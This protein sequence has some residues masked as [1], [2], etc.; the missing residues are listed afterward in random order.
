MTNILISGGAGYIGSCLAHLLIEKKYKVTIIDNLAT[1]YKSLIPKKAKF[2]IG[3]DYS[4]EMIK[5]CKERYAN[6]DNI[7][8]KEDNSS[9]GFDV[10]CNIYLGKN[11]LGYIGVPN[12]K[13]KSQLEIIKNERTLH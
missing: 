12:K 8:F 1:G 7:T 6:I 10:L 4:S 11:H 2:Y 13:N 5:R 3:I 9:E